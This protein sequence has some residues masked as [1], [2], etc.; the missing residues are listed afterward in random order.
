MKP[1]YWCIGIAVL[2]TNEM[3]G[4]IPVRFVVTGNNYFSTE[5]K[6]GHW[7]QANTHVF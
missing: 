2:A 3:V 6:L 1:V 4:A 7:M 5:L